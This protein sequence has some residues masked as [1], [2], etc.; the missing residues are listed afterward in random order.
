MMAF[1]FSV[2]MSKYPVISRINTNLEKLPQFQ[3]YLILLNKIT[4]QD[5]PEW[6]RSVMILPLTDFTVSFSLFICFSYVYIYINTFCLFNLCFNRF[7]SLQ[8]W[9]ESK[10][11]YVNLSKS[12]LLHVIR[13][14]EMPHIFQ[15]AHPS[16]QVDCPEWWHRLPNLQC[17]LSLF[18]FEVAFS[19][20]KNLDWVSNI[21]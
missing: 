21:L 8:E 18:W 16:Q 10:Y 9:F 19:I 20:Y 4:L 2:D 12:Q 3:V 17:Q 1:R 13:I 6:T 14:E 11:W 5:Y 7:V 15:A